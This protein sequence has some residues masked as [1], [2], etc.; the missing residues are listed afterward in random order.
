[1]QVK[2]D[3]SL[4]EEIQNHYQQGMMVE[5]FVIGDINV[6]AFVSAGNESDDIEPGERIIEFVKPN[7]RP[8]YAKVNK[9]TAFDTRQFALV[10]VSSE[11]QVGEILE[12]YS[13]E[14]LECKIEHKEDCSC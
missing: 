6:Y 2:L 7:G 11:Q 12:K 9:N 4:Y 14:T 13:T 3:D 1:M 8:V 10:S 5:T